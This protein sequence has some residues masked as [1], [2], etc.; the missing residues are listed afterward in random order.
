MWS[1]INL[2]LAKGIES[3]A[4]NAWFLT[5]NGNWNCVTNGGMV[6]GSLAIMNEDPTGTASKLLP[7]ALQSAATNCVNAVSPDGT[8]SETSDYW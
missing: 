4:N 8:W 5:T 7:L 2:G 3:H 6:V 1:I